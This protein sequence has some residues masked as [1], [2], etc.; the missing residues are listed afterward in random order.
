MKIRTQSNFLNALNDEFLWRHKELL[1]FRFY[2]RTTNSIFS[3][4]LIRAGVPLAYAHW[5]GFVKNGTELLLNFVSHQGLKN[6]ELADVYYVNSIKNNLTTLQTAHR[7]VAAISAACLIR[8]SHEALAKISHKNFVD[9]SSNL[10]SDVFEQLA[11]SIGIS[12][13]AYLHLYP[14]IDESIVNQRNKI[15]HGEYLQLDLANFH[16]LTDRV[17][18]LLRMY[19]TDL[20]NKVIDGSFRKKT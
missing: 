5:E 12:T 19:K 7:S 6:I 1:D 15:A 18:D 2:A 9:T 20:E 13:A 3:K 16:A 17:S 11:S 8:D 4:T 10:S 14:Y